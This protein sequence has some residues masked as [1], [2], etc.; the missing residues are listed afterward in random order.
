MKIEEN[1]RNRDKNENKEQEQQCIIG[2]EYVNKCRGSQN[3]IIGE[4][5]AIYQATIVNSIQQDQ[6]PDR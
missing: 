6:L 1:M 2:Y 3:T 5:D 4:K